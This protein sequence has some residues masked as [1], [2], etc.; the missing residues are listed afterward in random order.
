MFK[1]VAKLIGPTVVHIEA[2]VPEPASQIARDRQVEE[3]GSG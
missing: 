3:A 1:T 2:D